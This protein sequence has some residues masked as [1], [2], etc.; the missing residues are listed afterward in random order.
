M[1]LSPLGALLTSSLFVEPLNQW[2]WSRYDLR[3]AVKD[4][5]ASRSHTIAMA[6]VSD[7]QMPQLHFNVAIPART[8]R[9]LSNLECAKF[10]NS[11][12]ESFLD[13]LKE[14]LDSFKQ[15]KTEP[16]N[17]LF[18]KI[19]PALEA[20]SAKRALYELERVFDTLL[21]TRPAREH[22]AIRNARE[23]L[24]KAASDVWKNKLGAEVAFS[25]GQ[26]DCCIERLDFELTL[27]GKEMRFI[28]VLYGPEL[29]PS[30]GLIGNLDS[31]LNHGSVKVAY[32][33]LRDRWP[34]IFLNY[35][36]RWK[37]ILL[38]A[39]PLLY[40]LGAFIL[41]RRDPVHEQVNTAL[42]EGDADELKAAL[43]RREHFILEKF[44]RL[45]V[46]AGKNHPADAE[47]L[48]AYLMVCLEERYERYEYRFKSRKELNQ[49]ISEL[50]EDYVKGL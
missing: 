11:R 7:D 26:S 6:N 49:V 2:V 27:D 40:L 33:D 35:T 15:S 30:P 31:G 14:S 46:A 23:V 41:R 12:S 43:Q 47:A 24:R 38:L 10:D 22:S 29:M 16:V 21:K 8:L 17:S 20:G 1:F 19:N 18:P 44:R 34:E 4:D 48:R 3:W 50:L 5:L 25:N 37:K 28:R 13:A 32:E 45:C 42:S 36:P 39:A 9:G